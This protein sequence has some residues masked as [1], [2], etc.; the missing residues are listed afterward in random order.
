MAVTLQGANILF[1]DGTS[2]STA[3]VSFANLSGVPG[4]V[5]SNTKSNNPAVQY[6]RAVD[7]GVATGGNCGGGDFPACNCS[8]YNCS[9]GKLVLD[10]GTGWD[11][12]YNYF[13]CNCN[14][15]CNCNCDCACDCAC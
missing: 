13:Q 9:A 6:G 5:L 1:P 3:S 15:A 11:L 12:Y 8:N 2:L 7:G 10:G 4:L 14:N